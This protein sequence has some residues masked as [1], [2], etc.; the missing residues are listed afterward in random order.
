[1]QADT[2]AQKLPPL[3]NYTPQ[4]IFDY[5]TALFE[6]TLFTIK[7][8]PITLFSLFIFVLFLVGFRIICKA[9]LKQQN[10]P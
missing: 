8:T 7:E 5:L 2:T 10:P 1:M 3:E 4:E 6:T 9:T